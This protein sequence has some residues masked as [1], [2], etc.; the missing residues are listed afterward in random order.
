[1]LKAL[2]ALRWAFP[3]RV[4]QGA[5]ESPPVTEQVSPLQKECFFH[6]SVVWTIVRPLLMAL[7][8]G[9]SV[10]V[11]QLPTVFTITTPGFQLMRTSCALHLGLNFSMLSA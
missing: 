10:S 11:E 3:S 7:Q 4:S 5:A 6:V 2:T 8:G 9:V 1:M